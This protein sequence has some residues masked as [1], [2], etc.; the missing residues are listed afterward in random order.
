MS[1]EL[2]D[3]WKKAFISGADDAKARINAFNNDIASDP[4]LK[5]CRARNDSFPSH[6]YKPVLRINE[7][8]EV[9]G[10]DVYSQPNSTMEGF[11]VYGFCDHKGNFYR[12]G[13]KHDV[14]TSGNFCGGTTVS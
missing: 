7:S 12:N 3:F 13:Q 9:I 1:K 4:W 2:D 14:G 8:S 5:K 6:L 11:E 10:S